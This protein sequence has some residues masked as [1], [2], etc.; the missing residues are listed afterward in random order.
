MPKESYFYEEIL[1]ECW[2]ESPDWVEGK[3]CIDREKGKGEM[4]IHTVFPGVRL[5]FYDIFDGDR[6]SAEA[7]RPGAIKIDY[8]ERGR[9]GCEDNGYGYCYLQE[10]DL[11]IRTVEQKPRNILLPLGFFQ[12][13]GLVIEPSLAKES[14]NQF[15][16]GE[17]PGLS[18]LGDKLSAKKRIILRGMAETGMLFRR[19][20][21][22]RKGT[23]RGTFRLV[24][25]D[26]LE[27]LDRHTFAEEI[28]PRYYTK[29]QVDAIESVRDRLVQNLSERVPLEILARDSG[30]SKTFLKLCF[31]DV[32]GEPP[33]SYQRK[34]RMAAAAK[35]LRTGRPVGEIA[36]EMGYQNASKFSSAFSDVFKM[37]PNKY[38]SMLLKGT[39]GFKKMP[40]G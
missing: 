3:Y 27:L 20:F 23:R 18:P 32:Y 39:A 35:L 40:E 22:A 1:R 13:C 31:K 7:L 38:R 21:E 5:V 6:F 26:L 29:G 17:V 19:F 9:C 11:S 4:E 10:G 36:Q 33:Y 24:T 16:D 34:Q 2:K 30:I 37:T 25:M 8:C 28:Q 12:G 14:L 15:F